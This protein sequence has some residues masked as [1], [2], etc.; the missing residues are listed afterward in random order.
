MRRTVLLCLSFIVSGVEQ[1]AAYTQV[2]IQDSLALVSFYNSTGGPEWYNNNGWL[3]EPVNTWY[4]V[5][6]DGNRVIML[7][8]NSNNLAGTLPNELGNSQH[9]KVLDCLMIPF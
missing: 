9:W 5:T 6:V 2:L 3:I 7:I 8:I 4:G 1:Q